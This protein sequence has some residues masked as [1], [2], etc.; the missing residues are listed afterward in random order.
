MMQNAT[1]YNGTEGLTLKDLINQTEQEALAEQFYRKVAAQYIQL[2]YSD[3]LES[4]H[5]L[6][7]K[8][9]VPQKS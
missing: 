5:F 8:N 1:E 3:T 4:P 2:T 9:R 6:S 7:S